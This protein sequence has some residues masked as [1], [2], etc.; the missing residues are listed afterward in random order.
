MSAALRAKLIAVGNPFWRDDAAGIAVARRVRAAAPA[1][2][3]VVELG[4][5]PAALL[6]ALQGVDL[7]IVVDAIRSGTMPGSIH[8]IEFGAGDQLPDRRPRDSS[9]GLAIGD[10]LA[11]AGTL[12]RL[13][14]RVVLIGIEAAE[15]G[16]GAG[17]SRPVSEAVERVAR[18]VLRDLG[19]DSGK[20]PAGRPQVPA[21]PGSSP[22]SSA[23]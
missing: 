21:A 17:L 12:D 3:E 16:P 14:G 1:G 10:L 23:R 11:L 15:L 22:R 13:P 4:G 18:Q 7:V 19:H 8:R 6:E 9:H 20:V 2:V 5:D